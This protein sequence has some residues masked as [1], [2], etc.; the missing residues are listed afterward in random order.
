MTHS[1]LMLEALSAGDLV[2]AQLEFEAALKEDQPDMLM[3]LGGQLMGAGFLEE[4]QTIFEKLLESFP[5]EG[6]LLIS[7]AEIAIEN[8]QTDEAFGYLQAI[9][10]DDNYYVESLLVLA[11]LYQVLGVPEVS[12]KKIKEAKQILPEEP[13]LDLALAEL[14]FTMDRFQEAADLYLKLNQSELPEGVSVDDRIGSALS[15]LGEFEEALPY[16]EKANTEEQTDHRLFQLAITYIQLKENEKAI[17]LLEQLKTLN[18]S[19]EGVY[20]PLASCLL[21]EDRNPEAEAVIAEGLTQ[22]PY[23]LDLYH[24]ASDNA[25][26]LGKIPDAEEYLRKAI[27]LEEDKEISLIKLANLLL[28]DER[29]EES[30]ETLSELANSSQGQVYWTLAQAHNGLEKY[31]E[32]GKYYEE[33]YPTLKDDPDF[34]KDYGLFLREEGQ[35]EK[36]N[37]LF[38]E[39]LTM[40]PNDLEVLDLLED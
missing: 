34:L 11:D 23:S 22:N 16:L 27:T 3:A 17:Q 30:I 8:D 25:F 21:D 5:N 35:S 19:Y 38:K 39:Y 37:V 10:K 32:A 4:A 9:P 12:E 15:M 26:R 29:F 1:E 7:L 6:S 13:V 36:A 24:L 40:E 31:A 28:V 33:A 20:L 18:P 2:E 14:Y